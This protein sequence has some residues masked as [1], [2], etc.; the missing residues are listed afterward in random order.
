M[1]R[2]N[3]RRIGVMTAGPVP[4]IKGF[5]EELGELGWIE[6]RNV[7]LNHS[8]LEKSPM[9]RATPLLSVVVPAYNEAEG[10]AE[11][12]ARVSG[13][14]DKLGE[15]W[16]LVL[17]N[18][19][20]RD[21]TL[22]AMERLRSN[23]P[24]VAVV[25]LSRNFG[26]EIA[27][28]AGLDFAR[29]EAVVILDADLQDPPE[30]IP[31][32]VA[33]WR[34]GFDT[35]YAQ[36]RQRE[37]ETFVKRATAKLFYRVIGR[38]SRVEIPPDTGDFRLISRRVVDAL[39][40]LREQHRFMKGLFA[41]VGYP[42]KAVL[43]DRAPRFAGRTAWNYWKLW[44]LALEGITSFTIVPLKVATY[45]GLAVGFA[46]AIYLAEVVIRT[47]LFGNPVAGYPSLLAVV[48]FVGGVQ[49]VTLGVIGEYL[50]RIFNEV[51]QR[52]L[53]LV[54]R[55]LPSEMNEKASAVRVSDPVG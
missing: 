28:T 48:L 5:K 17:V 2:R 22:A 50:G 8:C 44:N 16:E 42:A 36:R 23:D 52:P 15:P 47:L 51:K 24:R 33:V 1:P 45:L 53:Y 19:G 27:T 29:G 43:Y 49:L 6:G 30:L 32:M 20:S 11:L 31:E 9:V 10:L 54:E 4:P 35:V 12:Y 13:V 7:D 37:G 41:W 14:M 25:N 34:Q 18:D 38:M 26:K 21:A 55:H 39:A 40:G 46:A 3:T